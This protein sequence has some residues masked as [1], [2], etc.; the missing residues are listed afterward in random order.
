MGCVFLIS[1]QREWFQDSSRSRDVCV[2]GMR[3]RERKR[4]REKERERERETGN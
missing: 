1:A 3:E 4:E 2:L